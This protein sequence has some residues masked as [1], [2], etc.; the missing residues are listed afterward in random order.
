M[1]AIKKL[2]GFLSTLW[3]AL[4]G[5]AVAFPGAAALLKL[6]IAVQNSQISGLYPASGMIFSAFATL[7]LIAYTDELSELKFARK[8]A[9]SGMALGFLFFVAFVCVRVFILDIVDVKTIPGPS[10][11]SATIITKENGLIITEVKEGDKPTRIGQ[12]GDPFDI[13]GLVLFIGTFASLTFGF[14]ALGIHTYQKGRS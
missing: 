7:F 4:A 5:A 14:T 13:L 11:S 10:Q 12:R 8:L 3:G 9:L 2:L 1:D 6:P